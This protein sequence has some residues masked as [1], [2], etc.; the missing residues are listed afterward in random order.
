MTTMAMADGEHGAERTVS[1]DRARVLSKAMVRVAKALGLKNNELA[2][3]LGVSPSSL[4]RIVKGDY[5]LSEHRKEFELATL[6]VRLYR[7]LMGIVTDEATARDWIR[8]HNTVLGGRPIDL[9]TS[10]VGLTHVVEYLDARRA[11]I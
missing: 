7:S 4:S 11:P 1:G 10:V 5:V 9:V 2:A 8:N 6:V 3:I